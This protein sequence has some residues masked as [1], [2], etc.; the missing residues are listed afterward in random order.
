MHLSIHVPIESLPLANALYSAMDFI[1]S[2]SAGVESISATLAGGRPVPETITGLT[3]HL[4]AHLRLDDGTAATMTLSDRTG[5]WRRIAELLAADRHVEV[6]DTA[7]RL[8]RQGTMADEQHVESDDSLGA[9]IGREIAAII[10]GQTLDHPPDHARICM[11]CDTVL[12]ACRTGQA[13]SPRT[14][15]RMSEH[16]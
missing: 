16:V 2:H 5:R 12:L 3:G 14:V 1:V 9:T 8:H 4:S 6:T 7:A 13:E 15:E 10:D 11:L